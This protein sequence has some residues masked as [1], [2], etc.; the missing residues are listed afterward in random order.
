MPL[1]VTLPPSIPSGRRTVGRARM[2]DAVLF[3]IVGGMETADLLL[4]KYERST[5][6]LVPCYAPVSIKISC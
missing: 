4:A 3:I 2:D 1:L 6:C 5:I